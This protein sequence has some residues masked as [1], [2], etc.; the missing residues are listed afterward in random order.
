MGIR[1]WKTSEIQKREL[2]EPALSW[3]TQTAQRV[4]K[5]HR[6]DGDNLNQFNSN[7]P[8]HLILSLD[9]LSRYFAI[10]YPLLCPCCSIQFH[11][12]LLIH[13]HSTNRHSFT[14][15]THCTFR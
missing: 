1:D 10:F 5:S 6:N 2:H 12:T 9:S 7:F 8:F 3:Q 14:L 13:L 11:D 15:S 4:Q